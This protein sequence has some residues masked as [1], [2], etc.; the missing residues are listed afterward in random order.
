MPC[1]HRLFD[2][3]HADFALQVGLGGSSGDGGI[4]AT[5][6]VHQLQLLGLG[7]GPHAALRDAVHLG[8]RQ[9]AGG[10]DQGEE[11]AIGVFNAHLQHLGNLR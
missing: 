6:L 7:A 3:D 2:I 10:G 8:Q 4:E 1:R 11:A 9:F 5:E